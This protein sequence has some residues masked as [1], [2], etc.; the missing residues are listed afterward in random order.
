MCGRFTI[1]KNQKALEA[2]FG[3]VFG[4]DYEPRYNAAPMQKLAVILNHEP[5]KIQKITWGLMPKWIKNIK[6]SGGII[7]TRMETLRDKKTFEKDLLE[8]RCLAIADGF[9]E[10][11]NEGQGKQPHLIRLKNEEPF[12]FPC[13]WEENEIDGKIIK[14]FSIITCDPNALMKKIHNRMPV[15]LSSEEERI[16][17]DPKTEKRAL[18]K[19]LNA[20]PAREMKADEVTK[21]VNNPQKDNPDVIEPPQTLL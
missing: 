2:R 5:D 21:L 1:M 13:I 15:I 14:T 7:N 6:K 20:Y 19:L 11:K 4:F 17:L 18:L 10:W 3:A 8:R 9:Y 16:W 12:A